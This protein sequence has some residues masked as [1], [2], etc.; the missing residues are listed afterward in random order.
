MGRRRGGGRR[1]PRT[2]ASG[3]DT[4]KWASGASDHSAASDGGERGESAAPARAH[5]WGAAAAARGDGASPPASSG[6][7]GGGGGEAGHEYELVWHDEFDYEGVPDAAKWDHLVGRNRRNRGPAPRER[8]W[9]MA[10]RR[11][12][13][14]VSDG[15][16]KVS[17]TRPTPPQ[18]P[19][20]H[21]PP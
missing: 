4:P 8:Q 6:D 18:T 15:T 11:E 17:A 16:L 20:Q 3:A 12:N 14:S 21:T 5:E 13:A 10:R 7:E 9:Y 2:P 1:T 19:A